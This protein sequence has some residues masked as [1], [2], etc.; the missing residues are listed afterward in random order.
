MLIV[1]VGWLS[2]SKR[3]ALNEQAEERPATDIS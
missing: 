1:S 2:C 3:P